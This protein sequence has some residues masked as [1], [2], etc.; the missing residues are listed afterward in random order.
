A[1]VEDDRRADIDE[2]AI[3]LRAVLVPEPSG[4]AVHVTVERLLAPVDHAH[5]LPRRKGEEAEM[6]LQRHVLAS[7][8]R[9]ADDGAHEAYLLARQ[10]EA[11]R[12]LPEVLVHPLRRDVQRHATVRVGD[13]KSGL[14]PE[15]RLIL[16]ADLVLAAHD[17]VG[18]RLRVAV[19][20]TDVLDDV[21]GRL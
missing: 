7:A 16:H 6:D 19:N 21:P 20:D 1:A 10:P 14:G 8:E 18:L 9:A 15:R 4:V 2:R 5:R 11:G 3:A 12:D 13:R 17:N